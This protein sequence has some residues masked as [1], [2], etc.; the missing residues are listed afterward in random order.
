MR[1]RSQEKEMTQTIIHYDEY[2]IGS[3]Y[4]WLKEQGKHI[5]HLRTSGKDLQTLQQHWSLQGEEIFPRQSGG[6]SILNKEKG[7]EKDQGDIQ[8]QRIFRETSGSIALYSTEGYFF[9]SNTR[10]IKYLLFFVL[11][12][13]T[14]TA[15]SPKGGGEQASTANSNCRSQH[16]EPAS[17]WRENAVWR[18]SPRGFWCTTCSEKLLE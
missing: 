14:Q 13:T 8:E 11:K 18:V 15:F 1:Y 10:K 2:G 7:L 5:F 12:E 17:R 4:K 16:H 3:S 6:K 9:K